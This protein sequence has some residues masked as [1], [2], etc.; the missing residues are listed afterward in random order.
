MNTLPTPKSFDLAI[1]G[2]GIA[3]CI[4]S[5]SLTKHNI[6]HTLYEAASQFGEIGA[7]IGFQP[8]IVKTMELISPDIK[9]AFLNTAESSDDEYPLFFN[10]S[11]GDLRKS[12]NNGQTPFCDWPARG[13]LRGGVH[14]AHFLNEL[15]KLIPDS[16]PKFRKR[17]VNITEAQDGNAV[18][19][20]SDGT[21]AKHSA[22]IG[23][24]G[25]KSKTRELVLGEEDAK[26]T[27]SGKYAY[28]GLIPMP[29]AIEIM[30]EHARKESQ[31]FCGYHGHVLTFPIAK[32]TILNVVAFSSRKEWDSTNWVITTSK[33]HMLADY[34]HWNPKV[35]SII[36]NVQK[37]DIWALFDH[38][39]AKTYFLGRTICL[40]GDAAHASTPHQGAGAGIGV[41][42]CYILGNLLGKIDD[43]KDLQ[44]VFKAYDE[45]RRPRTQRVVTTSREGGMMYE[46]EG[47]EGDDLEAIA[48]NM[49]TRMD[50]IWDADIVQD[51]ERA[52]RILQEEVLIS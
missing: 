24:D 50:W 19:Q 47:Q 49:Q 15:V 3:G 23:C 17:L 42:D 41:E 16:I 14:R 26:P 25:I 22:V 30:G 11:V 46:F 45:V 1:I 40:V 43:V 12:G 8:H 31:M 5:I 27:F 9:D 20:F 6:K 38:R 52:F 4:M 33:E 18:L 7:G 51:L 28:R 10:V 44:K 34:E 37:P 2:G 48:K 13:G 21:T 36:A 35:R 32:G 29:K 39:P